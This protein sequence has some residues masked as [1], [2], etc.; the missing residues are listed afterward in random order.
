LSTLFSA[1][2]C[3][4]AGAIAALFGCMAILRAMTG[5]APNQPY[6]PPASHA[7]FALAAATACFSAGAFAGGAIWA[8]IVSRYAGPEEVGA[9]IRRYTR[10]DDRLLVWLVR[11][12]QRR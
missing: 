12:A 1:I 4:L 10:R 3:I 8:V 11:W 7:L 2:V 9:A 6:A 5:L